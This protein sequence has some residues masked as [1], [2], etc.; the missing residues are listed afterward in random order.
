MRIAVIGHV[1]HITLGRVAAVPGP[2]EI[3]H[4]TELQV[5]PGGGGGLAF[6]QL[7]R[8]D[9][10]VHL[11]TALGDDEAAAFIAQRLA[12]SGARI[13]AARRAA[14]H[15]RDVVMIPPGGD[16]A[17][18]VLGEPLHPLA[19]DPLPWELLG[20]CDA[21]YFTAQDPEILRRARASKRLIATARRKAA[22][23]SSGVRADVALGSA[24]DPREAWPPG[25]YAV[26]P[27]ALVLT[28][29]ARGGSM[30]TA[31]GI[32]RFNAP[33]VSAIDG[34][35]YGAGDSFA[36]ALTYYLAAGLELRDACERA[37]R[38]GAAVLRG[39]NPVEQQLP[40]SVEPGPPRV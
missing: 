34:G 25:A 1:E 39:L 14:P 27:A 28:E 6:S 38:C 17:I 8:S 18:V 19:S 9:A 12:A 22:L 40:L 36:G 23:D 7:A 16:R 2:G 24:L 13:H 29:G 11:F 20:S 10:E 5:F 31:A 4:L 3:A 37:A 35:A 32:E 26:T 21:V 30:T 15:T 33:Q